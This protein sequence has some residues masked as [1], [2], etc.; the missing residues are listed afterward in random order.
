MYRTPHTSL[1]YIPA[2][3]AGV[4]EQPPTRKQSFMSS[5]TFNP[6]DLPHTFT[7][8]ASLVCTLPIPLIHSP[9]PALGLSPHHRLCAPLIRRTAPAVTIRE[10]S[11]R[12]PESRLCGNQKAIPALLNLSAPSTSEARDKASGE[13]RK[14]AQ[15]AIYGKHADWPRG[16]NG[17]R[18][19]TVTGRG[20]GGVSVAERKEEPPSNQG[21]E[22]EGRETWQAQKWQLLRGRGKEPYDAERQKR[23]KERKRGPGIEGGRHHRKSTETKQSA[24]ERSL[25]LG[26]IPSQRGPQ[27]SR[28]S[29]RAPSGTDELE[30]GTL[31]CLSPPPGSIH[32]SVPHW[33][34]GN[35]ST[36]LRSANQSDSRYLSLGTFMAC[37][38][39]GL[40]GITAPSN[41]AK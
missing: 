14:A 8:T 6:S 41:P 33:G 20:S 23:G 27:E 13:G 2:S 40:W 31:P 35:G 5:S 11:R 19:S 30:R 4:A 10:E 7:A 12:E 28:V 16:I 38:K 37:H 15:N 9:T 18:R 3:T 39:A 29:R 24:S 1:P 34:V 32:H 17:V 26:L 25:L 22:T 21:V 36:F